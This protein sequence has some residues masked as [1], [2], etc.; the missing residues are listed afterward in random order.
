[1]FDIYDYDS[2]SGCLRRLSNKMLHIFTV[3]NI[4]AATVKTAPQAEGSIEKEN[5]LVQVPI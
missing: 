1:M 2:T 3:T 5:H 4:A